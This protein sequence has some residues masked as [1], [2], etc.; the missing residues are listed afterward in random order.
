MVS[1]QQASHEA[2]RLELMAENSNLRLRLAASE[3]QKQDMEEKLMVAQV[4]HAKLTVH[5]NPL[6]ICIFIAM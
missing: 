4:G 1:K 3:Q 5:Y 2:Q 6:C